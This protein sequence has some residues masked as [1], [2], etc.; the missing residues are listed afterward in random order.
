MYHYLMVKFAEDV[1]VEAAAKCMEDQINS[2]AG[3]VDGFVSCKTFLNAVKRPENIDAV[4]RMEFTSEEKLWGYLNSD[5]H[6]AAKQGNGKIIKH[7]I[8]FDSDTLI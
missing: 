2:M 6:Q 4:V 3:V 1:S 8:S 7:F 5:R